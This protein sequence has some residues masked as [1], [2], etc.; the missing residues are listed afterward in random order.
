[1]AA[2]ATRD[3]GDTLRGHDHQR[4]LKPRRGITGSR[5]ESPEVAGQSHGTRR[6]G[7][8]EAGDKRRPAG[9]ETGDG[10]ERFSQVDVLAAGTRAKGR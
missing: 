5:Q 4:N 6:D 9:Q 10:A 3:C 8:R 2:S 1:M 7:A